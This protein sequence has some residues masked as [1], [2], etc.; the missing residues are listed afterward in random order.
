MAKQK[1][2]APGSVL[3]V[4]L[5]LG[6][7][8]ALL[9]ALPQ[10]GPIAVMR[11]VRKLRDKLGVQEAELAK[12]DQAGN[13]LPSDGPDVQ[14][15]GNRLRWNVAKDAAQQ[16]RFSGFE[17]KVIIDALQALDKKEALTEGHVPLWDKFVEGK[18]EPEPEAAKAA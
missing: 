18:A 16:R 17:L 2:E 10:Q 9:N 7:R 8:L 11:F 14:V 4:P 13:L 6:E 15:E 12:F 5:T 3:T 1:Q